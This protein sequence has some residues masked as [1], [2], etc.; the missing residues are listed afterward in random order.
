MDITVIRQRMKERGVSQ[1]RLAAELG[2]DASAVSKILTGVRGIKVK[3][4]AIISRLLEIS[5]LG[6]SPMRELPV[7]G[8]VSAGDWRE[9]IGATGET[10]ICPDE[11]IS[12]DAFVIEVDGD[13]MD[14]VVGDGGRIVV[15]PTDLAL[16]EGKAYVVRNGSGETTFKTYMANPARL[17]PCST[18]PAHKA[19]YPGQDQFVIIGRVVWAMQ[20]L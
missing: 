9:A 8:R 7:I 5:N 4:A 12:Q 11:S 6:Y 19:I 17:E 16:V 1:A 15:D 2:I 10:M 3:E 14:R 20:R 18:N 13:S